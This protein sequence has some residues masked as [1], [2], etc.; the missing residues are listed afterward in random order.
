MRKPSREEKIG[1][2]VLRAA[3]WAFLAVCAALVLGGVLLQRTLTRERLHEMIVAQ[4]SRS[5]QAPVRLEGVNFLLHQ[6]IQVR[7]LEVSQPEGYPKGLFLSSDYLVAKYRLFSLL[8]GRL[9]LREVRLVAPS[10]QLLR[11]AD[12]RWNAQDVLRAAA[13]DPPGWTLPA[14]QAADELSVERGRLRILDPGKRV[15]AVIERFELK[16][17]D[18]SVDSPFS[19]ELSFT[20]D[21]HLG[22][23]DVQARLLLEGKVDLAGLRKREASVSAETLSLTVDGRTVSGS[24]SLRGFA[25]PVFELDLRL[26]ALDS[27]AV[28]LYRPVPEG[29]SL[30]ESRWKA[31]ARMAGGDLRLESLEGEVGSL[32]A[33]AS[34]VV[35]LKG[36]P[37]RVLVAVPETRLESVAALF[38]GWSAKRLSGTATGAATVVGTP[39]APAVER[40]DLRLKGFSGQVSENQSLEGA[41]VSVRAE[42]GFKNVSA[43]AGRGAYTA[44]GSRFEGLSFD[45]AI[46]G[47]DMEIKR[48]SA[49]WNGAG[50]SLR[51][52]VSEVAAP[53][54][55]TLEGSFDQLRTDQTYQALMRV[56]EI[57]ARQRAQ[58]RPES[59]RTWLRIFKHS[60]PKGFPDLRGRLRVNSAHSPN[61][62]TRNLELLWDL[63]DIDQ[64]LQKV[65]GNLRVGFGPGRVANVSKVREAHRI[66]SLLLLPFVYMH[67]INA[68]AVMS[69][70]TATPRTLDFNRIYADVGVQRG[71]TDARLLHMDGPQFVGFADGKSDFGRENVDLRVLMRLTKQRG[72]LPDRLV[73]TQG[74]PS[75]ELLLTGD[76]NKPT[77][78]LSLRKMR[79]DDL[80]VAVSE[81]LKRGVSFP[82]LEDQLTCR[83]KP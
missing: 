18:Y 44:Y 55:V 39:S 42:K 76:L 50:L 41:D 31:R 67:E 72:Q 15:D 82:P 65:S 23:R 52:C 8:K 45:L 12:G 69:L 20:N 54:L 24:G 58:P 64:G 19:V 25:D 5:F 16:V 13:D 56:A 43:Q 36:R 32:R 9:E 29:I 70:D 26:P 7:G 57:R 49:A 3:G 47:G 59:E 83:R 14:L 78:N 17:R 71:V 2:L 62:A 80:E 11:R 21:S 38:S 48:L 30:P 75:I 1:R 22:G 79:A 51:G 77:A 74:R 60:I 6:G 34:G 61:F 63:R 46:R 10:I 28:A 66:L 53:K 81:G 68:K 27:A 4:L 73:D 40:L 35:G 37:S 33:S